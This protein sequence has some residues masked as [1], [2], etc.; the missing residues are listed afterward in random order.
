MTDDRLNWAV[1]WPD[2]IVRSHCVG[3]EGRFDLV[4]IHVHRAAGAPLTR[5]HFKLMLGTKVRI[6]HTPT[7]PPPPHTHT[8]CRQPDTCAHSSREKVDGADVH[9]HMVQ[10][11]TYLDLGTHVLW[12]PN[13]LPCAFTV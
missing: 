13:R 3:S 12:V 1:L 2:G 5:A 9:I 6:T 11:Y 10:T 8:L 7:Y 4:H